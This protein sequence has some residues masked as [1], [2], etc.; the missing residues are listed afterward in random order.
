[1]HLSPPLDLAGGMEGWLLPIHLNKS[2]QTVPSAAG[3]KVMPSLSWS[4]RA[5][6]LG[7]SSGT[8]ARGCPKATAAARQTCLILGPPRGCSYTHTKG[9]TVNNIK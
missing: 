8:M 3:E 6:S 4:G 5:L 1:M 9:T 7:M 2:M